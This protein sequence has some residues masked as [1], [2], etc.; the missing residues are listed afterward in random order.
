MMSK[1]PIFLAASVPERDL[2]IYVPDPVAIREAIRAL[3]AETVRERLLVFGG[4][5]A[6][7]P[8]VEQAARS[9]DAVDNVRIYQ[10]EFFRQVIPPVAQKFKNLVWTPPVVGDR[11]G[12][13]TLMR[14]QMITSEPFNACVCIGGMDGLDEEWKI[15][16]QNHPNAPALPVASTEGAA[17]RIWNWWTPPSS[18]NLP[19]DVKDRLAMDLDYRL[20]FRDLLG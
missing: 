18:Q 20:L 9:L 2:D 16:T 5:P 7:S 12:S 14:T 15:F 1:G 4:H 17:R 13:L 11:D 3:V 6:I 19:A 8:L 10:S